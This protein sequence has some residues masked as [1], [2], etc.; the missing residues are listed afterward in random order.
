MRTTSDFMVNFFKKNHILSPLDNIKL[1]MYPKFFKTVV[2][3]DFD[4]NQILDLANDEQAINKTEQSNFEEEE[5][6]VFDF[7]ENTDENVYYNDFVK[8]KIDE[9]IV[10]KRACL[11]LEGGLLPKD[12][13]LGLMNDFRINGSDVKFN[14]LNQMDHVNVVGSLHGNYCD[15][16]SIFEDYGF[17][18]EHNPYVFTGNYINYGSMSVEILILLM[19]I[20]VHDPNSIFLFRGDHEFNMLYKSFQLECIHKYDREVFDG[21]V[22]LFRTVFIKKS[23]KIGDGI[24]IEIDKRDVHYEKNQIYIEGQCNS[25]N[26]FSVHSYGSSIKIIS[27]VYH[28]YKG[29]KACILRLHFHYGKFVRYEFLPVARKYRSAYDYMIFWNETDS[30]LK[31]ILKNS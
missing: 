26:G 22:G 24:N 18:T 30:I 27:T 28:L 9:N 29:N 13:L 10:H 19:T 7:I 16:V 14:K 2:K 5:E 17:P 15:L 20:K 1:E 11:L 8:F 31:D 12:E 23:K 3:T 4:E 6:V 21:F 25:L